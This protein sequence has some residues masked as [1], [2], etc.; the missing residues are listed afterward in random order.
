MPA[1]QK[2]NEY[3]PA[4]LTRECNIGSLPVVVTEA[5]PEFTHSHSDAEPGVCVIIVDGEYEPVFTMISCST[6]G[7]HGGGGM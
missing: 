5:V 1:D 4:L 3:V 6:S 7:R 2:V